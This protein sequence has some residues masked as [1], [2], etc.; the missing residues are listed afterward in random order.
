[1]IVETPYRV[2]YGDTDQMGVVYY[3]NYLRLFEMGRNEY[4]RGSAMTYRDIEAR[5]LFLPVVSASVRYRRPARYDDLVTVRT[6]IVSV[7]GARV[8]FSYEIVDEEGTLLVEGETQ[9]ANT[10][11]RGKPVRLPADIIEL[12]KPEQE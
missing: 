12:L 4:L 7:K 10:D 8:N 2:I 5:G 3:A 6:R 1:M 11:K 9:H